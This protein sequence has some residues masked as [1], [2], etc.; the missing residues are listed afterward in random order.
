MM[1]VVKRGTPVYTADLPNPRASL[2]PRPGIPQPQ[3]PAFLMCVSDI[4][5][6]GVQGYMR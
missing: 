5:S 2:R 3:G 4:W 6:S 1:R